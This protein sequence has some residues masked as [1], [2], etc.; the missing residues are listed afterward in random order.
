MSYPLRVNRCRNEIGAWGSYTREFVWQMTLDFSLST[1]LVDP[2][3][4]RGSMARGFY[5]PLIVECAPAYMTTGLILSLKT[6]ERLFVYYWLSV[7]GWVGERWHLSL[8]YQAINW[9]VWQ[10]FIGWFS[11]WCRRH[12]SRVNRGRSVTCASGRYTQ[13]FM[14]RIT[15]MLY[16]HD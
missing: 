16:R 3:Y 2:R 12:S 4:T 15:K 14:W 5:L 9:S 10:R 7:G 1:V 13:K 6:C 11:T 8:Q